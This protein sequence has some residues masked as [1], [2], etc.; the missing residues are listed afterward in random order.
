MAGQQVALGDAL[1]CWETMS[2][3]GSKGF[4]PRS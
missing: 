3:C 1:A 2:V 4:R